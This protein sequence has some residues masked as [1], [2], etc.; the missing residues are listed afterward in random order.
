MANEIIVPEL[1]VRVQ[2]GSTLYPAEQGFSATF[3]K[4]VTR[5]KA[6]IATLQQAEREGRT[7]TLRCAKLDAIGRVTKITGTWAARKI[8]VAVDDLYYRKSSS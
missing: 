7:V 4:I 3:A 8:V 1:C 6:L 2:T 5:D